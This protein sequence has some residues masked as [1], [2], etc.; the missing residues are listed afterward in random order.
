MGYV[1]N[2]GEFNEGTNEYSMRPPATGGMVH[3]GMSPAAPANMASPPMHPSAVAMEAAAQAGVWGAGQVGVG[4]SPQ[5]FSPNG[6]GVGSGRMGMMMGPGTGLGM[7]QP[8]AG[9]GFQD[10][11][12]G[13]QLAIAEQMAELQGAGRMPSQQVFR[14]IIFVRLLLRC[15]FQVPPCTPFTQ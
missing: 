5:N 6:Q 3:A 9:M 4:H 12:Q 13:Q 8:G 7:A 11:L 1:V 10:P 15:W 2:P 14:F